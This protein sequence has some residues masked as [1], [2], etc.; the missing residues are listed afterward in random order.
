[1]DLTSDLRGGRIASEQVGRDRPQ[2]LARLD[3]V[4]PIPRPRRMPS[5]VTAGDRRACGVRAADDDRPDR[6]GRARSRGSHRRR[7]GE[8][9]SAASPGAGASRA[10]PAASPVARPRGRPACSTGSCADGSLGAT[11]V[12]FGDVGSAESS[13][14]AGDDCVGAVDAASFVTGS[15][16]S[17][18]STTVSRWSTAGSCS[19]AAASSSS[20]S[21]GAWTAGRRAASG[22][23]VVSPPGSK[24]GFAAGSPPSAAIGA[25]PCCSWSGSPAASAGVIG[26]PVE[27]T[28]T[29]AAS[30]AC[31]ACRDH[32]VA[33]ETADGSRLAADR[34][35]R[36]EREAVV[37]LCLA[38]V[39]V[40]R[41]H[42]GSLLVQ[43]RGSVTQRNAFAPAAVSGVRP[44]PPTS[45]V[46]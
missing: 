39:R 24:S 9:A 20:A 11:G 14:G 43:L 8:L 27:T 19:T 29:P 3:R 26:A 33:W 34:T 2:R 31:S 36:M 38:E 4:R 5:D 45:S 15:V 6:R 17:P 42:H 7:R 30:T 22:R 25:P 10:A 28:S 16:P 13:V 21:A 44:T 23:S 46:T 41:S 1:M 32:A 35:A 12:A 18:A 37:S 40:E